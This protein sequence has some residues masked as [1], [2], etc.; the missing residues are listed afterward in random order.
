VQHRQHGLLDASLAGGDY[1]HLP[2]AADDVPPFT[3]WS[4]SNRATLAR[5]DDLPLVDVG[6]TPASAPLTTARSAAQAAALPRALFTTPFCPAT[7]A[8]TRSEVRHEE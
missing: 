4:R 2:I 6:T 3:T 7:T 5:G 8:G 1:G